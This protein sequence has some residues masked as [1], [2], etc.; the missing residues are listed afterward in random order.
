M[1]CMIFAHNERHFKQVKVYYTMGFA[2][3]SFRWG[4]GIMNMREALGAVR[5]AHRHGYD[6]EK[7]DYYG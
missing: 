5:W 7:V 4:C 3:F 1:Y 2:H 6:T